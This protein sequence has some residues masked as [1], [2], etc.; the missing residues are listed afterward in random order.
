MRESISLS[1]NFSKLVCLKIESK[2]DFTYH[3]VVYNKAIPPGMPVVN[4]GNRENPTYLPAQVCVVIPGQPC[5]AKL[6]PSQTQQMIRFAVRKPYENAQSIV[7]TSPKVVGL[8]STINPILGRFG[9]RINASLITVPGRVLSAPELMY[10]AKKM[11]ARFGSWNMADLKFN[12]TMA[13]R[14]WSYMLIIQGQSGNLWANP[15]HLHTDVLK[16]NEALRKVGI[17]ADPPGRGRPVYIQNPEDA[18]LENAFKDS[19]NSGI[20]LLLVIIPS[21]NVQLYNRIKLLGDIK[22]GVHTICVVGSKFAKGDP[23]YNG[24]VSLKF[25]LKLGGVNQMVENVPKILVD[26]DRTMLVGIDVTH[27]SPGSASNAPSV[28]A[29]VASI[30]KSLG[31]FPAD[32]RIQTSRQEMVSDLGDM[33]KSRLELWKTLGKHQSYPDNI[34]IYRDGVSEGQYDQVLEK[35]L[36]LIRKACV[37]MYPATATKGGLPKISIVIVGKRH[38]T[39]FYPTNERDAD[40]SSNPTCGTV[41]DR[42]V[43]EPKKWDF[44]M[45]A[46]TAIQGTARPAHYYV[47]L[48]EIFNRRK[49]PTISGTPLRNN[50]DVLEELT[51]SMC[52]LF[53]RAT[54]AVS[55]CPPAYYADIVCERARC[56][57][58]GLF[59]MATPS[60]TQAPSVKSGGQGQDPRAEDVLIH[61]NLRNTMFYI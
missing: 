38:H 31:Q 49:I 37:D 59:D 6:D 44:F 55:I 58:S 27:P 61:P 48:D 10:K 54:K 16:L 13:L 26:A 20:G 12:A 35:E 43:T 53:G 50:A 40:R 21:T 1:L 3:T 22:Y 19:A 32:L 46:H 57:L 34:L 11:Y 9:V 33:M 25:N 60:G 24:N 45:Q 39:R 51:H 7:D 15:D 41:V 47:I 23:Q 17:A 36:P 42:G 4:V 8:N 30:D 29:I 56:Y 28:A 2:L 14:R 18:A 52:Y 5:N